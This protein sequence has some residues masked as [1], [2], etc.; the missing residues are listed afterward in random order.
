VAHILFAA[1]AFLLAF[2]LLYSFRA[3]DDNRLFSWAWVFAR[4]DAARLYLMLVGSL[5]VSFLLSRYELPEDAQTPFL[6]ALSFTAASL[7]WNEPELIVDAAR[8]FTQAKHLAQY[9]FVFFLKEWGRSIFAWTDLPLVPFCYGVLF[10]VFGESRMVIQAFTS[11]LFSLT[12]VLTFRI[13]RT[14]WDRETGFMAALLLLGMPYLLTQVPLMLVDVPTMFFILL[15]VSAF[16]DAL[17]RGGALRSCWS[18]ITIVLALCSK[19]SAGFML[20]VLAVVLVVVGARDTS[21]R[22]PGPLRRG[23]AIIAAAVIVSG[24]LILLKLDVVRGQVGLLTSY[25]ASGLERWMESFRSTFL[26]QV[27][28]VITVAAAASVALAVR[29]RDP[30]HVIISWPLVLAAVFTVR[31]IRYLLPLFPFLS[32]MAGYG[33]RILQRDD[34][35]RFV[36]ISTVT[37]SLAVAVFAYLPFARS[38]SVVN[39]KNAGEYLNTLDAREVEVFSLPTEGSIVNPLVSVP[40][41]DLFTGKS[42]RYTPL[43]QEL[44]PKD[45]IERSSLRFTWEFPSPAYYDGPSY[46]R[47]FET[48]VVLSGREHGALPGPLAQRLAGYRLSASFHANEGIFQYSVSARVYRRTHLP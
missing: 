1:S 42:L 16:L 32:L 27:H 44:P 12:A 46:T 18:V 4:S 47:P 40:L 17:G 14:L 15:S 43:S 36:L 38:I 7:F 35:R 11:V 48:V 20:S 26:F 37:T 29:N 6:A 25:Q 45:V 31:R 9:G 8:Y 13:G 30:K 24:W 39:L 22:E 3:H 33:L 5:I 19:Y 2:V 21:T 34:I 10:R 28:P 41:L 23:A